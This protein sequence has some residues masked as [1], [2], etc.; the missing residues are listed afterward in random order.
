M[1]EMLMSEC[2][3]ARKNLIVPINK[4]KPGMVEYMRKNGYKVYV[5][6]MF[7]SPSQSKA[8]CINRANENGRYPGKQKKAY[9]Q[10][11][12]DL[13]KMCSPEISDKVVVFDSTDF[14]NMKMIYSRVNNMD[15]VLKAANEHKN[16]VA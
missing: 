14:A 3:K 12:D 2:L 7:V 4:E 5:L 16:S 15:D 1:K 9:L 8:R 11:L 6:A 13:V 10:C